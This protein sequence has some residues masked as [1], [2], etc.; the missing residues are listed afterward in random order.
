MVPRGRR[1]GD[2]EAWRGAGAASLSASSCRSIICFFTAY[3]GAGQPRFYLAL[4]PELPNPGYAAFVVM[5]KDME[6]REQVRSRL[7]ASVD[8]Q[9]PQVWVRVTRLELGPPVGFPVQF[10]VV[11]PDTQKVREIARE[12]EAVVASSPKVRDVQLDWNDPVRVL[13][14]D[15][16]QDKGKG[17]HCGP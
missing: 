10:R 12:V 16:D 1:C 14:V 17:R 6:A 5:T 11:G 4:N 13:K 8:E 7:L 3:T 15:L 9:F 2:S